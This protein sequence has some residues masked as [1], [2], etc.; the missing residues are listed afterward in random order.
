MADDANAIGKTAVS[1]RRIAEK[2]A[3]RI[4]FGS[5]YGACNIQDHIALINSM[6]IGYGEKRMMLSENAI[7]VYRLHIK[8]RV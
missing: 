3:D 4:I 5:D 2:D 6:D 8:N 7:N 1:L